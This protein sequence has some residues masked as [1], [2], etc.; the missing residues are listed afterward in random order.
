MRAG[1]AM[2]G[3][4]CNMNLSSPCVFGGIAALCAEGAGGSGDG[5]AG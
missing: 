5:G 4:Y 3:G 2:S 1:I